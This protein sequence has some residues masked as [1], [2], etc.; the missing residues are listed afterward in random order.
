MSFVSTAILLLFVVTTT[1]NHLLDRGL[2]NYE[3]P[4][5]TKTNEKSKN[6]TQTTESPTPITQANSSISTSDEMPTG[7]MATP[8]ANQT[9][10]PTNAKEDTTA[11]PTTSLR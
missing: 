7:T 10:A 11:A 6:G 9:E 1:I 4:K 2:G 8:E 5:D 3:D